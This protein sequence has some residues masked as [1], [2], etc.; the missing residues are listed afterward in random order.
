MTTE[1]IRLT[2]AGSTPTRA[3]WKYLYKCP[4]ADYPY[5]SLI[6]ANRQRGRMAF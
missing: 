4:E 1:Q 3:Y 5:R 2:K 6:D